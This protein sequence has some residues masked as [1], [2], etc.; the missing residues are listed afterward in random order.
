[1]RRDLYDHNAPFKSF[2]ILIKF[3]YIRPDAHISIYI[4][5]QLADSV[6]T[7]FSTDNL[8]RISIVHT[9]DNTAA[10]LIAKSS[11]ITKN[12]TAPLMRLILT[13]SVIRNISCFALLKLN[14]VLGLAHLFELFN[15]KSWHCP[16]F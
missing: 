2:F 12:T 9:Y 16:K 10:A 6:L 14:V 5:F 1:M 11:H 4:A 3:V 13:G 7:L 8:M 15:R